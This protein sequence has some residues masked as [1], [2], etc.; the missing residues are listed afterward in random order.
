MDAE[1]FFEEARGRVVNLTSRELQDLKSVKVE[2][3]AWI[4]FKEEVEDG[5]RNVI[6]VDIV[7]KALNSRIMEVSRGTLKIFDGGVPFFGFQ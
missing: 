5:D 4:Q 1:T 7:D 2:K 6:R 3:T